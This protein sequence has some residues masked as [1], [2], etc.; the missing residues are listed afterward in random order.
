MSL[1]KENRT[2]I[3]TSHSMEECEALCT[4]LVIMV[5]GEFKCLGTPQRLKSKFGDGL[6][7][8]IRLNDKN[9]EHILDLMKQT[10]PTSTH[11]LIHKDLIEFTIPFADA[12]LSQIFGLIERNL[13]YLNIKDYSINQTTLDQVFVNFASAQEDDSIKS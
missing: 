8:I 5:N 4:R 3:L 11:S 7:I 10:F 1:I 9:Y 13:D 2:V 6:K 12:K